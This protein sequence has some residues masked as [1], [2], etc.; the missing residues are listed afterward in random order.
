MEKIRHKKILSLIAFLELI[1][2]TIM[3]QAA[4]PAA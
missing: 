1:F 4:L 3:I 2:A